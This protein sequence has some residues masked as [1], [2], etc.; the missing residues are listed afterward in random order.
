MKTRAMTE[1]AYAWVVFSL[2]FP[3]PFPWYHRFSRLYRFRRWRTNCRL[4]FFPGRFNEVSYSL[5]RN[6]GF[7]NDLVISR[8][9]FQTLQDRLRVFIGY[10]ADSLLH[11]YRKQV[12]DDLGRVGIV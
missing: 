3:G 6:V 1:L 8:R 4:V 2:T 10:G 11:Q 9:H 5:F 12:V 7:P